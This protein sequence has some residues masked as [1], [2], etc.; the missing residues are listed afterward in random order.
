M[1]TR[2]LQSYLPRPAAVAVYLRRNKVYRV[3]KHD[4]RTEKGRRGESKKVQFSLVVSYEECEVQRVDIEGR[5]P[6]PTEHH[7]TPAGRH[8]PH[9]SRDKHRLDSTI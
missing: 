2:L 9:A 4:V 5:F 1:K 6:R 3:F 7:F 8:S